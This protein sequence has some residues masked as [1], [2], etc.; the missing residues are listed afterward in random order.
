MKITVERNLIFN[1]E[2][3]L[4]IYSPNKA[5]QTTIQALT[6]PILPKKTGIHMN[7][8]SKRH[9]ACMVLYK[10]ERQIKKMEVKEFVFLINSFYFYNF[11]PFLFLSV[12][13]PSVVTLMPI[14]QIR[15]GGHMFAIKKQQGYHTILIDRGH[16][17]RA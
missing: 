4:N 6:C 3:L 5:E 8:E 17:N 1:W 9:A 7:T 16:Q 13:V 12:L 11:L 10:V 15:D 2:L 14:T